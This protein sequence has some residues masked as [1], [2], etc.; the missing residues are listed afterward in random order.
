MSL[1]WNQYYYFT[2]D[3]IENVKLNLLKIKQDIDELNKKLET[4]DL[5]DKISIIEDI[6]RL[7]MSKKCIN[8]YYGLNM[9][10]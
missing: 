9:F 5:D 8:Y 7:E 1:S 3:E 10:N 2:V 4:N 6:E